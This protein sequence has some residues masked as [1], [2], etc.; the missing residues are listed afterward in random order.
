MDPSFSV[1]F[2]GS[3]FVAPLNQ[4]ARGWSSREPGNMNTPC[5]FQGGH[6]SVFMV[7][8]WSLFSHTSVPFSWNISSLLLTH[9][10][11]SQKILS[12]VLN[13]LKCIS[14]KPSQIWSLLQSSCSQESLHLCFST[15]SL[16]CL[17]VYTHLH[18]THSCIYTPLVL[19]VYESVR[20]HPHRRH[21]G[22]LNS[23]C[24]RLIPHPSPLGHLSFP[25]LANY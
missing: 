14:L 19:A 7:G 18:Y 16:L 6:F 20:G 10:V 25:S 23:T 9:E 2:G 21:H 11:Y 24:N 17:R 13:Q 22:H 12:N 5:A 1:L 15:A 4:G 8:S 3:S